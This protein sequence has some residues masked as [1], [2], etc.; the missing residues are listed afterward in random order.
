MIIIWI[1]ESVRVYLLGGD[2]ACKTKH[3]ET[4]D[5]VG[6]EAQK[7]RLEI[8]DGELAIM[9]K[10]KNGVVNDEGLGFW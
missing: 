10:S 2:S 3:K 6:G 7:K 9:F 1:K 4:L 5:R 8:G